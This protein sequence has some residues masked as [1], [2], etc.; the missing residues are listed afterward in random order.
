MCCPVYIFLLSTTWTRKRGER[1]I[2]KCF[3]HIHVY[4]K[5]IQIWKWIFEC[6]TTTTMKIVCGWKERWDSKVL[7][8]SFLTQ[9]YEHFVGGILCIYTS[10]E[11]KGVA[12]IPHQ[13]I[14]NPSHEIWK[15][16]LL[17]LAPSASLTTTT[18][19][20]INC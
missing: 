7:A 16:S 17:T 8:I 5:T 19:I 15:N 1:D 9:K 4:T 14:I 20:A 11:L 2:E 10:S 13:H 18:T 3:P 12:R 6:R